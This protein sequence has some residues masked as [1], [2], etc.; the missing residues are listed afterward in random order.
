MAS[1][2]AGKRCTKAQEFLWAAS[3]SCIMAALRL[4]RHVLMRA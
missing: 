2:T 1:S 4:V 3:D